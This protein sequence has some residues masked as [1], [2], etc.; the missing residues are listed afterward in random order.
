MP[1]I[2]RLCSKIQIKC[3]G[4]FCKNGKGKYCKQQQKCIE[5]LFL[6]F[7]EN[8]WI[9]SLVYNFKFYLT[10]SLNFVS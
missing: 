10:L 1:I 2:A 9:K 8:S 4:E 7:V 5:N 6:K 3:T